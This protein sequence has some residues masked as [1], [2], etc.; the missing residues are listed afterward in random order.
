MLRSTPEVAV[1]VLWRGDVVC[2][3]TER[4]LTTLAV[5][6]F[7]FLL[8]VLFTWSDSIK[9]GRDSDEDE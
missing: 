7:L 8:Y 1:I 5:L 2:L 3:M 4:Q 6:F 9:G